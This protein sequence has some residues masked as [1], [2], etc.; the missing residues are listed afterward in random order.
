VPQHGGELPKCED[1]FSE[2]KVRS[3][4]ELCVVVEGMYVGRS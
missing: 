3:I 1:M 2:Y 4:D